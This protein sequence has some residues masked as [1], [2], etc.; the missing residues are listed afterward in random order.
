MVG[1]VAIG[2]VLTH[3][4]SG[5]LNL[6]HAA[7]GMYVAVAFYEL[8][9]TGELI[10]PVL[11]LPSRLSVV[12]APTVA[13]ALGVC[14]VL[15]AVLGGVIYLLIIR[16]LRHAP[17]LSALVASLGLLV[18]LMEIAR[19]RIGAQ[20]ATGLV[21]D[22]ILPDGLVNI[23]GVLVGAD[24]LWLAG[25]G[26]GSALLLAGLYRFTRFGRQ[27]RALADNE[28]GAVLLGISPIRVGVVNWALAAM[29]A[30]L[31]MV[32]AAPATRLDV[33]ASSLLIVPA[34][35]AALVARLRSFAGAALAGLGI[36]M[37]QSELMNVQ[38]EWTWLPDVGIQQGV[39]LLVILAALA[40]WGD[41]L[42]Q[43]GAVFSPRL[44]RVAGVE[45][46]PWRPLAL[47]ATVGVMVM[48]L[49]SEWRLAVVISACV[50]VI[51]L[52]VVVVTGLVGQVSFAP[53]AFAGIGAFTVIRLDPMPFPIA[54]LLGGIVAVAVGLIMGL[55]AVRVRGSQLAVA[56]L[57]GSLAIEE[58]VF[59]W[60]WFS[61]G[62]L[63]ARMPRPSLFGL[64]LGI[65]AV[66]AAYPRRAFVVTTLV[67]LALCLLMVLGIRQGVVGRRWRAVRDNERAASAV[68]IDVA[69]V[70]LTAFAVSAMLAG[71]GGALLGYQRQMVT[72]RS[73]ALFD[74]LMVVA[75]TYLAG[76][77]APSG[78]LL[79]GALASGGLL[80]VALA[81]LGDTGAANQFAVSGLTL[82]VVAVRLPAG[83]LG[84]MTRSGR[85]FRDR[86]QRPPGQTGSR[87]LVG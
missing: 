59:R 2:L 26:L 75:I 51:A 77:A 14:M 55:L 36:G 63:G 16:P 67:V 27:T 69:G 18:Y 17:P 15:A 85:T 21:I 8:R 33:S 23:G 31:L 49:G 46:R 57:A 9:A 53:Y 68:G 83:V 11:G 71:I 41:D 1:S 54:P 3:R 42:P 70:K 65:G 7:M 40:F 4:A 12:R 30:G 44:P 19:L 45:V 84:S 38:V 50:A 62:D 47:L 29:V 58:L 80:T 76:I 6:A 56:T 39:P 28:R 72:G 20:G 35:A 78:A 73:F 64:D 81:R 37:V 32:L 25:I 86:T 5:V 10:L 61:G 82:M 24:R 13:T 34:L 22:G 79:A 66:G 48:M 60:S 74:S 87:A 43:R 52:S